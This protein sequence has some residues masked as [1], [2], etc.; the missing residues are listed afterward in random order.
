MSDDY[1]WTGA[2]APDPGDRQ[3][4]DVEK[5]ERMLGQLRAPLPPAPA[6]AP[7]VRSTRASIGFWTPALAMAAAI[8]LMIASTYQARREPTGSGAS[9]AGPDVTWEVAQMDGRPQIESASRSTTLEGTGRL[10]VGQTL[11]TDSQSRARLEVSTIGQVT[12][13]PDTRVRLVATREGR[14]ELTLARGTLH[15]FITAPPGQ[16]IVNTPSSTATDLGC[17]YTLNVDEDGTGLLSVAA[18]WVAF[19]YK[20]RES[21][22]PAGASS[23]SDPELGPGTP[24]Y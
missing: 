6:L 10:A 3:A 14:H 13:D 1:L 19:E 12:V 20:G 11:A 17:V 7:R 18:G 22:V 15:A 21:F 4:N 5:L 2:G 8:V 9:S 16:F 24:R 23:R